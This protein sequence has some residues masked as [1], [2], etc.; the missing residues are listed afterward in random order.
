MDI[1]TFLICVYC[2]IDD[3][4]GDRWLRRRGP[5]P[6][7]SDA[8]VLTIE[9]VGEFL[10]IDTD[11]GLYR[12]FGWHFGDWFPELRRIHRTTFLR[13]AANLWA[14]KRELWQALAQQIPQD[15]LITVI[16]SFPVPVCR[17]ARAPRCQRFKGQAAFGH[18]R[19]S[20][21]S[22][23]GGG[24]FQSPLSPLCERGEPAKQRLD[25]QTTPRH[26][27]AAVFIPGLWAN[28]PGRKEGLP[29]LQRGN[30]GD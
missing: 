10:G 18:G 5:Q 27:R 9:V 11:R 16:D 15:D 6:R 3:W 1:T 2:L 28:H 19:R 24:R 23:S 20:N 17:F 13:Q 4:L 8:E 30:E 29:L 14:V 12:F 7:L 25:H 21:P 26:T 22:V